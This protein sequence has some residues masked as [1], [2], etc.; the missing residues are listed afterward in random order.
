MIKDTLENLEDAIAGETYEYKEMYPPMLENAEKIDHRAKVMFGYAVEAEEV[1]A[2]L[3]T[4]AL[5][6]VKAGKD[7][8]ETEFYLCPVCCYIEFGSAPE[9]CPICNVVGS[10]FERYAVE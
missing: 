5:E 1:H 4:K 8:E 3:Y 7:L 2:Q 6:A 9:N 10:R